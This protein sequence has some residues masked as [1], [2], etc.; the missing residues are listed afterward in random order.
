MLLKGLVGMVAVER[1][2]LAALDDGRPLGKGV[3]SRRPVTGESVQ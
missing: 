2:P 3:L 1:D